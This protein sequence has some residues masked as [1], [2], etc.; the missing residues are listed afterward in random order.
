MRNNIQGIR[1]QILTIDLHVHSNVSDGAHSPE[2]LVAMAK[3]RGIS[4]LALTDHDSV[5]GIPQ[6]VS[7]GEELGVFV[8]PGVELSTDVEV[9]EIHILGF[10][11]DMTSARLHETLNELRKGRIA[12]AKEILARLKTLGIDIPLSTVLSLGREGFIGR[13]QIFR[14]MVDLRYARPE[15]RYG[16]FQ[17]YL[18]KKGLAYVEHRGFSP[19][20]AVQFIRDL[21]GVP[22]LAHPGTEIPICVIEDLINAGLEGIEAYHPSHDKKTCRKWLG[23]ARDRGLIVTGG[24]DFHRVCPDK[25]SGLGSMAIPCDIALELTRRWLELTSEKSHPAP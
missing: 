11:L 25:P 1:R 23:F 18:G 22:V 17:R 15:E 14:A 16:D 9:C 12:R 19:E 10:Y 21:S 4:V 20:K 6:A 8:I 13:S 3:D 24:S 5:L 7:A 2:E